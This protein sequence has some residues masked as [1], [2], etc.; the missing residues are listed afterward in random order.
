MNTCIIW[1]TRVGHSRIPGAFAGVASRR[2][3]PVQPLAWPPAIRRRDRILQD[4][5][6]AD[7]AGGRHGVRAIADA[8]ESFATPFA[9]TIDLLCEQFDFRPVV[10]F[11][12]AIFQKRRDW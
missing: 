1:I 2:K 6:D 12:D 9:Q 10:Q 5:V 11:G 7:A 4:E 8:K 3:T